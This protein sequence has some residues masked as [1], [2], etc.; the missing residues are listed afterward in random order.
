ME[1]WG[2][3]EVSRGVRAWKDA[4]LLMIRFAQ[5]VSHNHISHT[6]IIHN[7][8]YFFFPSLSYSIDDCMSLGGILH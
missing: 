4:S 2:D 1:M 5:L 7:Q 3:A 8:H 6:Y